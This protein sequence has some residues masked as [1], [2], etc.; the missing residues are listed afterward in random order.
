[1]G[2]QKRSLLV[3]LTE[4]WGRFVD[5][6]LKVAVAFVDFRKAF[7]SVSHSHL[8]EKLNRQFGIDGQLYAWMKNYLSNRKQFTVIN[9]RKSSKTQVRCGVPQGSVLGP[10]LFTLFTNDLPLSI[11]S[12]DT[13]MYNNDTTVFCIGSTQDAA[14][15]LLNGA[16]QEL[17]TWRINNR[18]T[19]HP[20]KCEVLSLSKARFVDPLPAIYI[21]ESVLE[22]KIK[23]RLLG[24]TIDHNLSWIP[25]LQEVI[26]NFANKLSLLKKSRFL[27]SHVCE[28]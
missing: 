13:F 20:G 25:H 21:G 4:K 10:T 27:P 18:L 14:C 9:G 17:F 26:K 16:L 2:L 1:M 7:D 11:L 3:R 23:T 8:L 5:S 28:F 6:G 12:G 22:Y 19:P 24:V 15:N